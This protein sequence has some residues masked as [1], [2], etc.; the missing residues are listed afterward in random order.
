[1][2]LITSLG[3]QP[4][5]MTAYFNCVAVGYLIIRG[6]FPRSSANSFISTCVGAAACAPLLKAD[7][8]VVSATERGIPPTPGPQRPPKPPGPPGRLR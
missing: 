7:Q 6:V 3:A 2:G 8:A 4:L 1:M 5:G